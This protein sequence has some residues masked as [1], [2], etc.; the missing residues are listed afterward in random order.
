[1]V[2]DRSDVLVIL[3]TH[4]QEISK[5]ANKVIRLRSGEIDSITDQEPI[6]ASQL[7]W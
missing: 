3:V 6:D 1:M 7:K 5:I 4:N 2:K